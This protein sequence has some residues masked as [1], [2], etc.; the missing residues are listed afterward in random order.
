MNTMTNGNNTQMPTM[1]MLHNEGTEGYHYSI[2]DGFAS[3]AGD[4]CVWE[5]KGRRFEVCVFDGVGDT[6]AGT[7]TIS[8][9]FTEED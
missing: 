2:D 7:V 9:I 3:N 1:Q 6:P 4:G 5:W 8:E